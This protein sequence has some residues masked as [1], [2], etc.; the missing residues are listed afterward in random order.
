MLQ[1]W[2]IGEEVPEGLPIDAD[3]RWA[4]ITSLARLG[5]IGIAEIETEAIGDQ[6]ISGAQSAAGARAA[7]AAV[8][9][10]SVV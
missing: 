7:L 9:R 1:G 6:T 5:A 10:K 2:L 8:D 3:R 4:I